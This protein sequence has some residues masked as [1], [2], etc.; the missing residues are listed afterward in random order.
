MSPQSVD[1]FFQHAINLSAKQAG[2]A[3]PFPAADLSLQH[4]ELSREL[5]I[6]ELILEKA[7]ISK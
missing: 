1:S 2:V 4:Q 7:G 6:A 3:L 5:E